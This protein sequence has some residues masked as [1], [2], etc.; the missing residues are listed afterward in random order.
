MS[1]GHRP[2]CHICPGQSG[3]P[4]ISRVVNRC[5]RVGSTGPRSEIRDTRETCSPCPS[6]RRSAASRDGMSS[7]RTT[8]CS[9][10]RSFQRMTDDPEAAERV[11]QANIASAVRPVLDRNDDLAARLN[12]SRCSHIRVR[13]RQAQHDRCTADGRRGPV[14][15][16]V[17]LCNPNQCGSNEDVCVE[18]PSAVVGLIGCEP[19]F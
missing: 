4:A 16:S 12:K 13:H 14:V 6:R 9:G 10:N 3:Q 2:R 17:L 11:F 7:R 15:I 19:T 18:E 5:S 8:R 1:S